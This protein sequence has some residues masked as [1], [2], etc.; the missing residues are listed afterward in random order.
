MLKQNLIMIAT[1]AVLVVGGQAQAA[2]FGIKMGTPLS[3][4]KV[5][6]DL[7]VT[8]PVK[9]YSVSVPNPNS[10]IESYTV[11]L[12]PQTGV[13]KVVG[14]GITHKDDN[15]GTEVRNAFDRLEK[16]LTT[17]YG[18]PTSNFDFIKSS[19]IWSG[20]NEF[21]SSVSTKDRTLA[22][23]WIKSGDAA[24]A[25]DVAAIGLDVDA[26]SLHDTYLTL[27]Y[28]FKNF[29]ACRQLRDAS[30]NSGL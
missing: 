5:V 18:E 15:D 12:T 21:A 4:L 13:C 14:I 30:D 1:S 16:S 2:G 23:Y 24:D 25:E 3:A 7:H 8:G 27:G 20:V 22:A 19:S 29:A 10:E 9:A 6:A 17:K 26:V 28:E 11:Y